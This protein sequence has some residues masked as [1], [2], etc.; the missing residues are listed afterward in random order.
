[1]ARGKPLKVMAIL[2]LLLVGAIFFAVL[3]IFFGSFRPLPCDLAID[4]DDITFSDFEPVEGSSV[5]IRVKVWNIGGQGAENITVEFYDSDRHLGKSIIPFIRANGSAK[6]SFT[7]QNISYGYRNIIV[8]VNSDGSIS[9]LDTTNNIANKTLYVY[10]AK[11]DLKIEEITF[12]NEILEINETVTVTAKLKNV[13]GIEAEETLINFYDR[14]A[15]VGV[16]RLSSIEGKGGVSFAS[17]NWT[18]SSAGIHVIKVIVEHSIPADFDNSNNEG[19]KDFLVYSENL[20][21]DLTL[22][23]SDI[24]VSD[25]SP[26][27]GESITISARVRN[28]GGSNSSAIVNFCIDNENNTLDSKSIS[29]S[30]KGGSVIISFIWNT[31]NFTGD[32]SIIIIIS[33][34]TNELN[35]SNNIASRSIYVRTK[36]D[37]A[38]GSESILLKGRLKEGEKIKISATV[39]N[40]GET[41]ARD[42]IVRFFADNFTIREVNISRIDAESSRIVDVEWIVESADSIRVNVS[43]GGDDNLA[44]NE[45]VKPIKVSSVKE[46]D[47][48]FIIII[49][50]TVIGMI[51]TFLAYHYIRMRKPIFTIKEVFVIHRDGRLLGHAGSGSGVDELVISSMLTAIQDF[52]T[53]SFKGGKLEKLK[54]LEHGD[55][56]ILI[57]HPPYDDYFCHAYLAVVI[58]GR[59]SKGVRRAMLNLIVEIHKKYSKTLKEWDGD[60]DRM[61]GVEEMIE[62]FMA[63]FEEAEKE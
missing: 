24:S 11:P 54:E 51:G 58:E 57:Q 6:A 21:P 13:G 29:V 19:T 7:W 30:G 1:M 59:E 27:T 46:E 26:T 55:L 8:K 36:P 35:T 20:P 25:D 41:E 60:M 34:A 3:L 18:P 33:N 49:P 47:N 53:D 32:R 50:L 56:R 15:S 31:D 37:L 14:N 2:L 42:V 9:E 39:Q 62:K 44:N 52:V 61:R 43:V 17:L 63:K 12:S 28:S 38:I 16:V 22:K 10:P 48:I 5:I 23:S 4:D 40:L 45:A